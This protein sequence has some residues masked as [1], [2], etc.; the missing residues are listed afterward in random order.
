MALNKNKVI[1]AAQR[2]AQKGQLDRAISELRS[3]VD[4]DPEDM[5]IW[6]RIA[7]LQI[8]KG[9]VG[10]AVATY[11]R[12]ANYYD[13]KGFFLKGV[14][15][16][17]QIL[18]A[19]P[20]LVD[21]HR[22]LGELYIKLGLGPEAIGQFQ[23][24]VGTYEREGRHRDSLELLEKIVELGPDDESNRIRLA[25][26]C[27]RQ[28]DSERAIAEFKQTLR[29][30]REKNRVEEY[31]QVAE[32][33]LYLYPDE[34][35]VVR[36]LSEIYLER[37]DPKRALARLQILFRADPT[38]P[39]TLDLLA[40][41]FTEIGQVA[42]AISV[43][44]ELARI[45]GEGGNAAGQRDAWV[46]LLDLEPD[47]PEALAATGGARPSERA[48]APA[49][50]ASGDQS[51]GAENIDRLISD[52]DLLLKYELRDHAR[53]R[54]AKVLELDPLNEAGQKKR[55][56][57]ALAD[58]RT[59]EAAD[60]LM[61]LADAAEKAGDAQKAMSWLG[62]LIQLRP[63][64]P[65]AAERMRRISS[66][67]ARRLASSA[68]P[69]ESAP[70]PAAD[71]DVDLG[72]IDFDDAVH[73]P[74]PAAGFALDLDALDASV[75][76]EFADLLDD[77]PAPRRAPLKPAAIVPAA[78]AGFDDEFGDL[79][80]DAPPPA[81]DEFGDLLG[82][83]APAAA[84]DAFGH[85]LDDDAPAADD[86]FGDLLDD[87]PAAG[88]AF[89]DLLDD[90]PAAADDDELGELG[91]LLAPVPADRRGPTAP[92]RPSL[93]E[94]PTTS[95]TS[96]PTP[97]HRRRHQRPRAHDPRAPAQTAAP[98]TSA[99]SST[100][101]RRPLR[102]PHRPRVEPASPRRRLRRPPRRR[103]R[104][105]L[106]RPHR[107]RVE[108]ASPRRRLRRPPHRRPRADPRPRPRRAP[109]RRL[110]RR[111]SRQTGARLRRPP[112]PRRRRPR[113]RRRLRRPPRR[114]P[115]PTRLGPAR[116]RAHPLPARGPRPHHRRPR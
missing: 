37:G 27:A 113:R 102:P 25:E 68:E 42:K 31:V 75:D 71:Y 11:T 103:S 38:E 115:R 4:E 64:D 6:H 94:K 10:Q 49:S 15:V 33:L 60:A 16:Y 34:L 59:D 58:D 83:D 100:T 112:R 47:D 53:E 99:T 28:S 88:D 20:T 44:R 22:Q 48:A 110:A 114:R 45:H 46:R 84:D 96:S 101:P 13:E 21:A 19:D 55:R 61:R 109:R 95:A 51:R 50:A 23:I 92:S 40:R 85:L 93:A 69:I 9:A 105:P 65:D 67:M 77:A 91:D 73:E 108:P 1:A 3:I 90:A 79:L 74:M 30:L 106:R 24:V 78:P 52:V 97:R 63:S 12:I 98:T 66:G 104:R 62:E 17:K 111:R 39:R 72:E 7:D 107:P 26:A 56:D 76:D 18:N 80:G 35:D 43:Y 81:D 5:R 82:D 41:S 32:R 8:R 29:H 54:L 116:R 14:A 86:E 2:F 70:E 87:A 57:L 36:A 89:G